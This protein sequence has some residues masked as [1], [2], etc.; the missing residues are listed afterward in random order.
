MT[1]PIPYQVLAP[2]SVAWHIQAALVADRTGNVAARDLALSE[3]QRIAQERRLSEQPCYDCRT[4]GERLAALERVVSEQAMQI[5]DLTH[6]MIA[7]DCGRVVADGRPAD[8][9]RD[10]A[11]ERLYGVRFV[12]AE[13]AG[14]TLISAQG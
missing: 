14:A 7:L 9:L 3:A 5:N 4:T 2:D 11:L 8:I 10:G 13:V 12:H 1:D 6:R